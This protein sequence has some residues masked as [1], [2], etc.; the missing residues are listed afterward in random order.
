MATTPAARIFHDPDADP[1]VLAGKTVAVIGYGNQGRSQALNVRDSGLATIVGNR[2][3]DYAA[4]A[5]ADGFAVL[6]IGDACAR[7]DVIALLVPDEVMPAVYAESV[8]P[9][10]RAGTVLDFA[11][12]YNVAFG[13]IEAPNDVDVVLIA[14]RMIGPGVRDAYLS[15]KGF[16][17]FIALHQDASGTGMAR[18]L[19]LARAVGSTRAGCILMS[20]HDEATLDLFTEQAFG[21]A[22]GR[23][24]MSAVETLVGAGY[25]PE[26]VLLE[27]YLSGELAYAFE[28]IRQVGMMRQ[29]DFHSHTSQYGSLTRSARGGPSGS[30]TPGLSSAGRSARAR[31]RGRGARGRWARLRTPSGGAVDRRPPLPESREGIAA[32]LDYQLGGPSV[33][34]VAPRITSTGSAPGPRS[35]GWR[36]WSSP[37]SARRS[38]GPCRRRRTRRR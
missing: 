24:F 7:A 26:A 16:P 33:A 9:H 2:D 3:D 12:G 37:G 23:V 4:Q 14:P 35:N 25:P 29:M 19:A 10:L 18:L 28:K 5:R 20:M 13:L 34:V 17:S 8:R 6:P 15:G 22:F 31:A 30:A 36:A 27:L 1:A 21:P 32:A 11:S 38:P